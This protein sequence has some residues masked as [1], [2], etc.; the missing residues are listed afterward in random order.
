VPVVVGEIGVG[1]ILGRSGLDVVHAD[2]AT[3]S[4]LAEAGFAVLM[5]TVGMHVPLRDRRLRR[6]LGPGALAVGVAAIGASLG[7]VVVAE[8]TGTGHIAGV[9]S[10]SPRARRRLCRCCT[11]ENWWAQRRWS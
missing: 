8:L 2:N 1:V 6:A 9:R 5:L 10:F 7:G 11:N 3:V 4:F